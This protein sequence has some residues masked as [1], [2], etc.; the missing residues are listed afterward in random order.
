M[1][2]IGISKNVQDQVILC[3]RIASPSDATFLKPSGR[4]ALIRVVAYCHY[5]GIQ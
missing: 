2:N 5:T 1:E 3:G 4:F